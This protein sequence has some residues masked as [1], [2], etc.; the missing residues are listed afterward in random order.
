MNKTM[1]FD[2]I[3]RE[4]ERLYLNTPNTIHGVGLSYKR[5]NDQDTGQLCITFYVPKKLVGEE[6]ENSSFKVPKTITIDGQEFITDVVVSSIPVAKAACQDYRTSPLPAPIAS[7]RTRTRPLKGGVTVAN[8]TDKFYPEIGAIELG[9][10]GLICVD[11]ESNSLVGLTNNHVLIKD[12]FTPTNQEIQGKI[13]NIRDPKKKIV[14]WTEPSVN[15]STDTIG[16]LKKYYPISDT[17]GVLNYVD[18]ALIAIQQKDG[19]NNDILSASES[20]KQNGLDYHTPMPFANKSEIDNLILNRNRNI[21][22]SSRTTGPKGTVNCRVVIDNMAAFLISFKKQGKLTPVDFGD[23]FGIRYADSSNNPPP[24]VG[25]DSGS[26]VIADFDGVWKVV[27]LI[28]A[29]EDN[30]PRGFACR[31]DRIQDALNIGPWDG[32]QK[33]YTNTDKVESVY[34]SFNEAKVE[35]SSQNSMAW[36]VKINVNNKNYWYAGLIQNPLNISQFYPALGNH[37]YDDQYGAALEYL[38]YFRHLQKMD[39]NSSKS[40]RFYEVKIGESH[41]FILDSDP[42]TGGTSRTGLI[43]EGAGRGDGPNSNSNTAYR[44]RQKAWFNN[45]IENSNL[46]WKFVIFHHPSYTSSSVHYGNFNLSFEQGWRLDLATAVFNGHAHNYERFKKIQAGKEVHYIVN[47]CG[48]KNLYQ[49]SNNILADSQSRHKEYGFTRVNVYQNGVRISFVAQFENTE[50]DFINIGNV[51]GPIINK[52][53][54]LADFGN[55]GSLDITNVPSDYDNPNNNFYTYQVSEAIKREGPICIFTAGDNSYPFSSL[56]LL[57]PNV[58]RFYKQ[59]IGDYAE[60]VF[61]ALSSSTSEVYVPPTTANIIAPFIDAQ[62]NSLGEMRIINETENAGIIPLLGGYLVEGSGVCCSG[63]NG[64]LICCTGIG[65]LDCYTKLTGTRPCLTYINPSDPLSCSYTGNNNFSYTGVNTG[66]LSGC[67]GF[68]IRIITPTPPPPF[69]DWPWWGGTVPTLPIAISGGGNGGGIVGNLTGF[70]TGS[71]GQ[72]LSGVA[73]G[74]GLVD[75]SG[76]GV[77]G[78]GQLVDVS[79]EASGLLTGNQNQ[80]CTENIVITDAQITYGDPIVS[81]PTR[82]VYN[83]VQNPTNEIVHFDVGRF[84]TQYMDTGNNRYELQFFGAIGKQY[85]KIETTTFE[86]DDLPPGVSG[87]LNS[88][89]LSQGLFT[90]TADSNID[91]SCLELRATKYQIDRH[92]LRGWSL[93]EQDLNGPKIDLLDGKPLDLQTFTVSKNVGIGKITAAKLDITYH[94]NRNVFYGGNIYDFVSIVLTRRLGPLFVFDK[95]AGSIFHNF[96]YVYDRHL[97]TRVVNA[98]E[99]VPSNLYNNWNNDKTARVPDNKFVFFNSMEFMTVTYRN[100]SYVLE[101]ARYFDPR[102]YTGVY[103][104]QNGVTSNA[105]HILNNSVNIDNP[106]RLYPVSNNTLNLTHLRGLVSGNSA[107]YFSGDGPVNM[108]IKTI[109]DPYGVSAINTSSFMLTTGVGSSGSGND[110]GGCDCAPPCSRTA[111]ADIF[112]MRVNPAVQRISNVVPGGCVCPCGPSGGGSGSG[113]GAACCD[114]TI[115]GFGGTS[116]VSGGPCFSGSGSG[117]GCNISCDPTCIGFS[118]S[119]GNFQNS[120]GTTILVSQ[121]IYLASGTGNNVNFVS[122]VDL[123]ACYPQLCCNGSPDCSSSSSS[124]SS[125]SPSSAFIT[126][127]KLNLFKDYLDIIDNG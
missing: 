22:I 40:D 37:D 93:Y 14:Q 96:N 127:E 119:S 115:S 48:G 121:F 46:K 57:E 74:S 39:D 49:F 86:R 29:S 16:T 35:M 1:N 72:I 18:A 67:S 19:N 61:E 90:G 79:G 8:Y 87:I 124:S 82:V 50:K 111:S 63:A 113:S 122:G 56:A 47:G 7:N 70:V 42:V 92:P 59:Y 30:G 9:T 64:Q 77:N 32:S 58:G 26:V 97:A 71:G 27:G 24:I 100:Y 99:T 34:K 114:S 4:I 78:S 84:T 43:T 65:N 5:I 31:I 15:L 51:S 25:G 12:A 60:A 55:D 11:R 45:A 73:S 41:F 98:Y 80:Q 13:S 44:D 36:P 95:L 23:L 101:Q 28:F 126:D 75:L 110:D 102:I 103:V 54:V 62:G 81:A 10:L 106:N 33:Y 76:S 107:P 66:L 94:I 123:C 3:K 116:A 91:N 17:A 120:D 83:V 105:L 85:V 88:V 6:L 108:N 68:K 52:F 38:N 2:N 89:R 53:V 112:I 118:G 21:Y 125:S 109:N 117:S 104:T 20:F 69:N